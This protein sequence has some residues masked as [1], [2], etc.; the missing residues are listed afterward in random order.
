[1]MLRTGPGLYTV[2]EGLAP[3]PICA[4]CS[5]GLANENKAKVSHLT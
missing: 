5:A 1:M 4:L 2:G 3:Y